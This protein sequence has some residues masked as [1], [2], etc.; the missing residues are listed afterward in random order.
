MKKKDFK[1]S[2]CN[3][4]LFEDKGKYYFANSVFQGLKCIKCGNPIF[5]D[6]NSTEF[7]QILLGFEQKSVLKTTKK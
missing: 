6:T 3:H 2:K 5:L 7:K 1:C 4:T